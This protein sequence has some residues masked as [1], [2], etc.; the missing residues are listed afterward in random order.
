MWESYKVSICDLVVASV[1]TNLAFSL[2]RRDEDEIISLNPKMFS[3][4]DSYDALASEIFYSESFRNGEDPDA[5]LASNE[6]LRI[7]PFDEFMYL[8]TAR[9][10]V[11]FRQYVKSVLVY[12]Q[13]VQLLRTNYI[14][15]PELLEL[16]E[17]K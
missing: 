1:I 2:V 17:T 8:P 15:R 4:P 14:F 10:L 7:T 9:T 13:P 16:P 3:R 11:K 6:S 5:K 12:P